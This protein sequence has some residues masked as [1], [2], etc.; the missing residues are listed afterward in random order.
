MAASKMSGVLL[1]CWITL[2]VKTDSSPAES[3]VYG[4]KGAS[5]HLTVESLQHLWIRR[6]TWKLNSTEILEH[7]VE[8]NQTHYYP[9]Y[10]EKM[11]LDSRDLS[12]LIK[13]LDETDQGTYTAVITETDGVISEKAKYRLHVQDAV[14]KP[15]IQMMSLSLSSA[16]GF[17]NVSVNCSVRDSWVYYTCDQT[18]CS[19]TEPQSWLDMNITVTVYNGN[20]ICTGSNRVSKETQSEP[21]GDACGQNSALLPPSGLSP[22]LLKMLVFSVG[23]VIMVSAV[24]TVHLKHR[25]CREGK[26]K[27][28]EKMQL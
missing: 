17:C 9:G 7:T 1:M 22:C 10:K 16:E 15:V 8:I 28:L 6:I 11:Q 25:F 14:S 5:V 19:Q 13:N 12:L 18:Q 26:E 24:I 2:F 3:P 27:T 21:L 23:L 4:L 20:I